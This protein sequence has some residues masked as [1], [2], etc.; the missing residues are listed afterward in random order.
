MGQGDLLKC[1]VIIAQKNHHTKLFQADSPDNIPP[2]TIVDS[3]IVHPRQYD[4]YMCAQAGPIGTSRPTHYHVLLDEIGFSTDNLQKL[5]L[6]LSYVHQR[7]TATI[8]VVAAICYA[9]LAAAQ[10]GQFMKFKEF[11]DT[12]SGSGVNSSSSA[13]I[14]E[15]PLLHADELRDIEATKAV[16]GKPFFLEVD[17]KGPGLKLDNMGKAILTDQD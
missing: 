13:A 3:S 7:S 2:R 12:S 10:M 8:F 9:H 4:F 15:L 17:I 11:A 6:S 14:P 5:V 1:I 16:K